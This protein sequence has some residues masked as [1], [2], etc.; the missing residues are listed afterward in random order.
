M[1]QGT[2]RFATCPLKARLRDRNGYFV[3]QAQAQTSVATKAKLIEWP[4]KHG[5]KVTVAFR[6]QGFFFFFFLL[7]REITKNKSLSTLATLPY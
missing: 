1:K 6:K 7:L 5:V 2:S 3:R 4:T